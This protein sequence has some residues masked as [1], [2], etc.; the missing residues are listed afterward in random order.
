[1][2]CEKSKEKNDLIKVTWKELLKRGKSLSEIFPTLIKTGEL[3]I[4][5]DE[6]DI[7]N[8]PKD[9]T[10]NHLT[11]VIDSD[12]KILTVPLFTNIKNLKI[13]SNSDGVDDINID[14][15][16]PYE[17]LVLKYLWK[18]NGLNKLTKTK[19][20]ITGNSSEIVYWKGTME[21]NNID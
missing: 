21:A 7:K 10:L 13:I 20:I 2:N 15:D 4:S 5:L 17:S 19:C 12:K 6:K 14:K 11:L 8:I 18:V 9:I 1:M 16:L 3:Q